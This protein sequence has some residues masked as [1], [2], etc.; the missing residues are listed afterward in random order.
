[1]SDL[2]IGRSALLLAICGFLAVAATFFVP[3]VFVLCA[4]FGA[5][6]LVLGLMSART[7][8]SRIGLLIGLVA[9]PGITFLASR[10]ERDVHV[11]NH[12]TEVYFSPNGGCTDAVVTQIASAKRSVLVQAYSFT[13]E[14]IADALVAAHR[15]GVDVKIILDLKRLNEK[16]NKA[17]FMYAN[18]IEPLLDE[19]KGDAHNKLMII[20]S[21]TVITGSMNFS[22]NGEYKNAENLLVLHDR[23]LATMYTSNWNIHARH[24]YLY[25]QMSQVL[26]SSPNLATEE[27]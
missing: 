21:S 19:E 6:T 3:A 20:D 1:M 11:P 7:R 9:L 5:A 23:S 10:Y 12:A 25:T 18:D 15:R 14:P 16:K 24:S 22:K 4:L 17:D 27:E 13:S 2:R 8:V 26:G